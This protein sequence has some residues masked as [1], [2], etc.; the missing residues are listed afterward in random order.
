M[1]HTETV[2]AEGL[3]GKLEQLLD[4]ETFDAAG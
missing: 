2:S 1:A 3:E 4:V